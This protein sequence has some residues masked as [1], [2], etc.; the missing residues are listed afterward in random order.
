MC[1]FASNYACGAKNALPASGKAS[2]QNNKQHNI[3]NGISK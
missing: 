2:V 1:N 3:D